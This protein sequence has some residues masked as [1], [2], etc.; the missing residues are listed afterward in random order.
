MPFF[1][2][3]IGPKKNQKYELDGQLG[4]QLDGHERALKYHIMR[5]IKKL[6]AFFSV[7]PPP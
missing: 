7:L 6:G 5:K 2:C 4:G 1:L 3:P